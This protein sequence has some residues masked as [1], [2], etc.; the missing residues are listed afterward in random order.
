MAVNLN[1]KDQ[2]MADVSQIQPTNTQA[3]KEPFE[4]TQGIGWPEE[5]DRS[6]NGSTF[7]GPI[8]L[9][10]LSACF[11]FD[12]LYPFEGP[13]VDQT[14]PNTPTDNELSFY[15][16]VNF[17]RANTVQDLI[18]KPFESI[19]MPKANNGRAHKK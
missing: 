13:R 4:K 15:D 7:M 9:T 16:A 17:K 10:P 14:A 18:A 12:K 3:E 6:T 5:P 19:D 1:D 2:F 11:R 8:S